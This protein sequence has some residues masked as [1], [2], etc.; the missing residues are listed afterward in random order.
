MNATEKMQWAAKGLLPFEETILELSNE[1]SG[2]IAQ[3]IH[4]MNHMTAPVIL[5]ML[6]IYAD[7]IIKLYPGVDAAAREI[8]YKM[9]FKTV[10]VVHSAENHDH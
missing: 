8:R 4:P 3:A 1:Y 2:R 6:W 10:T 9:P 5:S 7:E